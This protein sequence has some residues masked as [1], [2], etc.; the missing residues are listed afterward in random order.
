MSTDRQH[1]D[2]DKVSLL[3]EHRSS[4][5][6][7]DEESQIS[8]EN[9]NNLLSHLNSHKNINRSGKNMEHNN[10]LN[11]NGGTGFR[12]G[13]TITRETSPSPYLARLCSA[14]FYG[15]ASFLITV[16]NKLVL[17]SCK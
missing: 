16:V 9:G 2:S 5:S 3:H 10:K 4:S 13:I 17:T 7:N 12:N 14:L 11:N 15:I 8:S 1:D 6:N